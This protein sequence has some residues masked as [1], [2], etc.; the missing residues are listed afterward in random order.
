MDE[1]PNLLHKSELKKDSIIKLIISFFKDKR[2]YFSSRLKNIIIKSY[3]VRVIGVEQ[4]SMIDNILKIS[5]IRVGD[6]M[7][8]R[9]NINAVEKKTS[10]E[11]IKKA[12]L[13]KEHSRMPVY[14]KN[15]DNILGFIH[16]KDLTKF[17][18]DDRARFKISD[19]SRKILYVPHSMKITNLLV[20]MRSSGVHIA[21]ILDEYGGTDGIITLED[22]IEEIVGE[23][24]DEHDIL[25]DN[26]YL[27]K[28]KISD[29]AFH[30]G[31]RVDI[32]EVE[33]I[34]N[35][36]IAENEDDD[37]ETVGGFMFFILK[38][39]PEISESFKRGGLSFK[40]LDSDSKSIKLIEVTKINN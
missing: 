32:E 18:N 35:T 9:S 8:P 30:F 5:Q 40:V 11:E 17:I 12:I 15:L 27:T 19:V 28:K 33:E 22:I 10:L 26:I 34:F 25:E 31:G 14:H 2:S 38:K 7:V 39:I 37:F 24:K 4:K 29:N 6:I 16:C 36:N 13:E 1:R 20:K 21:I 3:N 23:I